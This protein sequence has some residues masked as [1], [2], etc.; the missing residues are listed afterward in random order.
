MVDSAW[1]ARATSFVSA[2]SIVNGTSICLTLL[3]W[4]G[5]FALPDEK[6]RIIML[7][8]TSPFLRWNEISEA[9]GD[10]PG[11]V[12]VGGIPVDIFAP[13]EIEIMFRASAAMAAIEQGNGPHIEDDPHF[14]SLAL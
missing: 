2:L 1:I 14:R 3:I 6:P 9:L 7:P 5:Y 4:S 8:T 12:A 10:A 13:A 11:Y